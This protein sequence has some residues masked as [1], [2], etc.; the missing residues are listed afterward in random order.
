MLRY[1]SAP[2]VY[3]LAEYLIRRSMLDVHLLICLF[4]HPDRTVPRIVNDL[5]GDTAKEEFLAS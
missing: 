1:R 5:A 4:N 3:K 2:P